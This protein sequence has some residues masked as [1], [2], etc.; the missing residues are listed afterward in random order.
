MSRRAAV[1]GALLLVVLLLAGCG[2]A[3]NV[4]PL[5]QAEAVRL[6]RETAAV[7]S[8]GYRIEP[9]DTLTIKFPFHPER[10]QEAI[11]RPDGSV[12]V[13]AV[14]RVPVAGMTTQEVEADLKQRTS[15]RLKD[16]EVVVGVTK[17]GER[18]VYVGGEVGRPGQLIYRQGLTP[19]QAIMASGGFLPTAR[20]DSVIIVRPHSGG[21]GHVA[22]KIDLQAVVNDG[23]D[24]PV[25]L[26]PHDVV[27]V[28]RT[29]IANA[30]VWV[31]QHITDLI[32]FFRLDMPS[33]TG[34]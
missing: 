1:P 27:F 8:R 30:N 19:L 17:F 9:G 18:P 20:L 14:G 26:A 22:R 15:N 13:I 6:Q 31:R 4:P 28:P 2:P 23:V 10:D 3:V 5:T 12:S 25:T 34:F 16:P 29:P 7:E 33:V 11:V 21:E 32:P 24:E